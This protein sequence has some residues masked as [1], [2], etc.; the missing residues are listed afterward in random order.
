[1]LPTADPATQ[2]ESPGFSSWGLASGAVASPLLALV[3]R[4]AIWAGQL[5]AGQRTDE[6]FGAGLP[7]V[8]VD[9]APGHRQG[10]RQQGCPDPL[11]HHAPPRNRIQVG[12]GTVPT[13]AW[14]P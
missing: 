6:G 5:L 7:R 2:Y 14:N 3:E 11:T 13:H 1:S 4:A 10:Q 8:R 12:A 9:Q